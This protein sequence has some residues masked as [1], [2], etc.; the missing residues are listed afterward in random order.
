M[1]AKDAM[2]KDI[3]QND[4]IYKVTAPHKGLLLLSNICQSVMK[5][6]TQDAS[7]LFPSKL[8]QDPKTIKHFTTVILS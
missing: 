7:S 1:R 4:V 3:R 5:V 8:I 6:L 2:T